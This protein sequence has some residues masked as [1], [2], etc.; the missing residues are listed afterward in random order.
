MAT[1]EVHKIDSNIVGVRIAEE[2]CLKQ[3]PQPA[4]N[5]VWNPLEPN[6]P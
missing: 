6:F 3:L 2:E 5:V 1:C 4:A